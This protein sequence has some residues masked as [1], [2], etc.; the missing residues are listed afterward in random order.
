MAP[1]RLVKL[2]LASASPRRRDLLDE[3]GIPF[4]VRKP[5]VRERTANS[6][7]NVSPRVL[8]IHNAVLKA[9]A[10]ARKFP[11]RWVLG[12]DTIVVF[13][14]EIFGKP[15]NMMEARRML[16][17]LVGQEHRVVT[18]VCLSRGKQRKTFAVTSWVRFKRLTPSGIR[19]YLRR[20][21]PLDKAGAYA[22]QECA[23]RIIQRVRGSFSNVVGLPMERLKREWRTKLAL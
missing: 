2:I 1:R 6:L 11:N 8:A 10:V 19:E 4:E 7:S 18:G 14:G 9:S 22:A 12:A 15:S 20:I 5:R 21:H 13:Q 3:A 17:R 23:D 16:E